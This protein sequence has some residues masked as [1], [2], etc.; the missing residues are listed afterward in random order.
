[1]SQTGRE[2][3]PEKEKEVKEEDRKGVLA[4]EGRFRILGEPY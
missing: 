2:G 1:V 3:S 4:M